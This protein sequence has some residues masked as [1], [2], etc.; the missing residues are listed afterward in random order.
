MNAVVWRAFAAAVVTTWAMGCGSGDGAAAGADAQGGSV[1]RNRVVGSG[2]GL[3]GDDAS[4]VEEIATPPITLG[5][6]CKADGDCT[7]GTVCHRGTCTKT[8]GVP[9]DCAVEQDCSLD[10]EWRLLC[11]ERAYVSGIGD[12]CGAD[13]KCPAGTQCIGTAYS[14]D[15]VCSAGCND[16][17][18]CPM[19]MACMSA[20]ASKFC[21]V[22]SFCDMCSHAGNCAEGDICVQSG[23]ERFCS[24]PCTV[25]KT[26]C[27]RFAACVAQP[28]GTGA[29][30]HKAGNCVGDGS[31]CQPCSL[32]ENCD[33][34]C[35]SYSFSQESFCSPA[36]GKS[37]PAGSKCETGSGQCVPVAAKAPTC[38]GSLSKMAEVGDVIDDYAMVGMVDT[39]D[40]GLLTDEEPRL[41]K[42][43]HFDA[44]ELI[45]FNVSAVWC[46][47]CQAEAVDLRNVE[48]KYEPKGVVFLQTLYDGQKP[49]QPMTMSLLKAWNQQLKP[50]GYV[51]MDPNRNV[52]QYNIAGSSPLNMIID[53]KTHKVL[54]KGNGYNKYTLMAA[55]DSVL[56]S[57][58]IK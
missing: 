38:A 3:P 51:G 5:T 36:C 20:G 57:K 30:E 16:D 22:R 13:G 39:N 58:G 14:P 45:L 50:A 28:D 11:V 34:K 54:Y 40:D 41:I 27:K 47:A 2:N 37:C 23:A 8:C 48:Q 52:T 7:G 12:F 33:G 24:R 49:G 42:L 53:A 35:L 4:A 55:L 9:G 15:A 17:T 32:D 26:E 29:C 46:S 1:D 44:Y 43:S 6:D 18:D 25:G 19:N 21:Q 31:F 56:K 10:G